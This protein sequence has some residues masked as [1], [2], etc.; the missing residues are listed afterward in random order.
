MKI[1]YKYPTRSRPLKF[2]R[3]LDRYYD[4]MENKDDFEFVISMDTD[5]EIMYNESVKKYLTSKKNLNSYYSNNTSK[6]MAINADIPTKMWDILVLV[7]DDMIPEI[8]G[9]DNIIRAKMKENFP[10]TDGVLWFYDGWRRDLNTLCILG[11]KYFERFNYIYHPAYESF[12]C[13]AE[14]TEVADSLGKQKFI[15]QVII[16]HLHPDIV[17]A[18]QETRNKFAEFLPEYAAAG[19]HGHDLL[20]QKNSLEGDPDYK[21]YLARKLKGFNT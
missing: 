13:D 6:I 7:S 19:S 11:R 3:C 1:L 20:W 2:Q 10:D 9:Y 12:W 15:D 5:D 18:D 17:M 8:R 16:R 4:Y 14:F 21:I